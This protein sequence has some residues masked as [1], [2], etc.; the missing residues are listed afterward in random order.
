[1]RRF[2]A[3]SLVVAW[4]L[5]AH[6]LAQAE[7]LEHKAQ[8]QMNI[9]IYRGDPLGSR[10]AGTL[11][12]YAEPHVVTMNGRPAYLLTGGEIP[13]LDGTKSV[14]YV[15]T[16]H[17]IHITPTLT[18][19]GRIFLDIKTEQATPIKQPKEAADRVSVQT[20]GT[21]TMGTFRRGETVKVRFDRG[22]AERQTWAEIIVDIVK[23]EATQVPRAK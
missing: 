13:V 8:F 18:E 20:V 2:I 11:K 12:V 6:T 10:E 14:R 16:G 15:Q 1:M 21:R 4:C 17:S 5:G 22:T 23:N 7:K 9:T 3:L 19:D